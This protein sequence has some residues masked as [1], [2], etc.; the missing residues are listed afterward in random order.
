MLVLY[1]EHTSCGGTHG[2]GCMVGRHNP[3][4]VAQCMAD[5]HVQCHEQCHVARHMTICHVLCLLRDS[6]RCACM[7][8]QRTMRM[9]HV[10]A[11]DVAGRYTMVVVIWYVAIIVVVHHGEHVVAL[12]WCGL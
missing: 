6:W 4:H 10:V 9:V 5:R 3:H 1:T 2:A 12:L 8:R 11:L 7:V